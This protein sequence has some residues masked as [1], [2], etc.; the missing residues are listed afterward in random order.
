MRTLF[1]SVI[2]LCFFNCQETV[3]PEPIVEEVNVQKDTVTPDW[4][5]EK[6]IILEMNQKI[7]QAMVVENDP[8][9]FEKHSHPNFR[10]IAPGGKLENKEEVIRGVN[11][12]DAKAVNLSDEEIIF[13]GNTAILTGKMHI[14]G[15][16][17]P[18]G[19]LGPAKYM[20]VF[21]KVN[22]EWRM[23]SRSITPCAQ[24]AIDNGFC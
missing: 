5:S 18:L 15:S 20:T 10:V 11:S 4:E 13:Y 17:Q 22:G 7:I 21:I 8:S 14:D 23:V 24:I 19:K 9:V 6:Q 2:L 1:L 16:M 12:L 3:Q